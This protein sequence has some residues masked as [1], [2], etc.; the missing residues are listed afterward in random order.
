[1]SEHL[2][3]YQ[4]NR[5]STE[6]QRTELLALPVMLIKVSP[7]SD[8]AECGLPKRKCRSDGSDFPHLSA[9]RITLEE[10]EHSDRQ[11]IQQRRRKG[12]LD[13]KAVFNHTSTKS[14]NAIQRKLQSSAHVEYKVQTVTECF[15]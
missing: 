4:L 14:R 7:L 10:K 13:K 11:S 9:F 6:I 12:T 8:G 15:I 3:S 5:S 1:M 2:N